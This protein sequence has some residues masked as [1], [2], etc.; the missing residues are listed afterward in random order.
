MSKP[1]VPLS[2]P[3]LY[4]NITNHQPDFLDHFLSYLVFAIVMANSHFLVPFLTFIVLF[5]KAMSA[6]IDRNWHDAHATFYGD[7]AGGETMRKYKTSPF[8]F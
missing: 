8:S 2:Q 6:P 1:V 4:I 3:L 5:V 7:M